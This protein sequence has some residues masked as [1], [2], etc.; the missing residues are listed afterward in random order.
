MMLSALRRSRC[1][2][3]RDGGA[4][5]K[6]VRYAHLNSQ[7]TETRAVAVSV[8]F[9]FFHVSMCICHLQKNFRRSVTLTVGSRKVVTPGINIV[10]GGARFPLKALEHPFRSGLRVITKLSEH[11]ESVSAEPWYHHGHPRVVVAIPNLRDGSMYPFRIRS[12]CSRI[13]K[14][15]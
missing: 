15:D 13:I 5:D 9:S 11:Q 1:P 4:N 7:F 6:A 8:F 2:W 10:S 3:C 14:Y 12:R